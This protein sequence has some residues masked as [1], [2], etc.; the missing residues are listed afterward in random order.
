MCP[1]LSEETVEQAWKEIS[2]LV[3]GKKVLIVS[4]QK[5]FRILWKYLHAIQ[6]D[7]VEDSELRRPYLL[8]NTE[9]IKLPL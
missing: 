5:R 4:H 8:E 7:I 2:R 1:K 3:S 9:I 6:E